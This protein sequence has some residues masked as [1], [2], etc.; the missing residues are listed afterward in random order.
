M[1]EIGDNLALLVAAWTGIF[2]SGGGEALA[3]ILDEKVVWHGLLPD[4]VCSDRA[5]VL[6]ILDR[7]RARPRRITRI[8]AEEFGDRVAISVEGPD[9]PAMTDAAETH[10]LAPG[11]PRS[12]VFTFRDGKV[13]RMESLPS[14]DAAFALATA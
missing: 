10:V 14:R 11:A 8:E 5:Q 3:G 4:L 12:L 6:R 13:V 9:F 1:S 7:F 2:R